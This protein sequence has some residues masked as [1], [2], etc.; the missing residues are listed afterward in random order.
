MVLSTEDAFFYTF[1]HTYAQNTALIPNS[2]QKRGMTG[3]HDDDNDD[4]REYKKVESWAMHI[5]KQ[6]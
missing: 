5:I 3:N 6:R 1:T 4:L 2:L